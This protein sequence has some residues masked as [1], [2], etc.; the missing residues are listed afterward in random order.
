MFAGDSSGRNGK[1]LL[2]DRR[3][4]RRARRRVLTAT[5]VAPL[6]ALTLLE[7]GAARATT[8]FQKINHMIVLMQENRSFDTYLG[9]LAA[10]QQ[11]H[12][13]VVNVEPEPT[14]GIPQDPSVPGS[15]TVKPFHQTS[16]CEVADLDH[17]W[18][19]THNEWDNGKMDGFV[20]QNAGGSNLTG[21]QTD[22][23][24]SRTMGY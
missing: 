24:G 1:A 5:L 4:S 15:P 20:K 12:N 8:P 6:L 11:S 17:S 19:G 10:Y 3:P 22:P 18:G 7:A 14:T 21:T 9:Q 2:D 16:Y 13:E 23:T